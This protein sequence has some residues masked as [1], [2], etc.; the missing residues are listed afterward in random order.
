MAIIRN[1]ASGQI[2][3]FLRDWNGTVP[4]GVGGSVDILF[5]HGRRQVYD[6]PGNDR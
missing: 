2:R 1:R 5:S 6:E 4:P 3:A